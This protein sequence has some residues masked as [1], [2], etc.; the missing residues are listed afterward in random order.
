MLE[1]TRRA[2]SWRVAFAE[3]E[4]S[5]VLSA[6]L[7]KFSKDWKKGLH[8]CSWTL[9]IDDSPASQLFTDQERHIRIRGLSVLVDG[10]R[11]DGVWQRGSRNERNRLR[12]SICAETVMPGAG[13]DLALLLER[14]LGCCAMV[15]QG[16]IGLGQDRAGQF[17]REGGAAA[18]SRAGDREGAVH[19]AGGVGPAVQAEAVPVFF[20]GEPVLEDARQVLRRNAAARVLHLDA[21]AGNRSDRRGSS[22][23]RC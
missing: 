15:R 16:A 12:L 20:G 21:N 14:F 2:I 3:M 11:A 8:D 9:E 17:Q 18:Q 22:L 6:S 10:K 4:Q 19:L 1:W 23:P 13:C 5:Y 7:K